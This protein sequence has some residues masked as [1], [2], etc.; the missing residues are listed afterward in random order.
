MTKL[1]YITKSFAQ[2]AGV[3]RILADKMNYLAESTN[4]NITLITYEQGAHK[5]A[6]QLNKAIKVIDINKRFFT[7]KRYN[8]LL[9]IWKFFQLRKAFKQELSSILLEINPDIV[10]SNTYSFNLFD[11]ILNLKYHHIIESH[12][13]LDDIRNE[14]NYKNKIIAYFA[15]IWDNMM[16]S[17]TNKADVLI[18]LTNADKTQWTEKTNT[19]VVTIPN[20]VTFYPTDYKPNALSKRIIC[21][22]RLHYQKGF[23][24]LIKAWSQIATKY[25]NWHIDVF[26]SGDDENQLNCLISQYKLNDSLKINKPVN[27]IYDEYMNSAFFVLSSR[28]EGLPLVLIEAMSSGLA[29]VAFDCPNGPS[30]MIN[31][32][33]NGL[34]VKAEDISGLAD[35]IE[36]MILHKES[37]EQMGQAARLTSKKYTKENIMPLW[38]ELFDNIISKH[39]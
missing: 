36:W 6:Y 1:V 19:K 18:T 12:I 24:L 9:R 35:S 37:R 8:I 34:L 30:E 15:R 21:V 39:K 16:F 7:L 38:I 25:P 32:K 17:Y 13:C 23:D 28:F 29:C 20:M 4:Y 14:I 11:I 26:G 5:I 22:G 33:S 31:H 10:I 3:E 27:N 2:K